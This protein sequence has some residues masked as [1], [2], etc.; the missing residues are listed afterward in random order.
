M[1]HRNLTR[2]RF[3]QGSAA[4]GAALAF[5]LVVPSRVFGANE[6]L[7]IAAIGCGGKGEV[8]TNGVSDQNL[9]A[10]CDVDEKVAANTFAKFPSARRYKDYRVMLEKEAKNI[11]AVTVSTPDHHHAPAAL[12]AM[13]MGKHVYCQKPLTHTVHEARLMRETAA[14]MKVATQMGNQGHSHPETRR[15]VEL[16]RHGVLGKVT[17]VHVWT[18]RPIWP[19]GVRRPADTPPVPPTLDWNLFLGPAPERPYSP[20]YHPF[21]WRGF[22]DFGTGALGD[23]ACH[24]MDLAFFALDLPAP[25]SV[26]AKSSGGNEESAP[27]WSVIDYHFPASG[28]HPALTMTW[29][30]GGRMPP[31][32]VIKGKE[33]VKN[34]IVL[35]GDKDT[36]YV[37]SYWGDGMF[38]SGAKTADFK[39]V[40]QSIPRA[41]GEFDKGHYNEWINACKGGP[42]ALSNFDYS[43]PMTETVLL[44][45]VALRAGQPIEWD[46][47]QLRVTNVPEANRFVK[48]QY[49]QGWGTDV[50]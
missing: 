42:K 28:K 33:M 8:D 21:V 39:D 32:D 10:L 16:V 1:F 24:C 34:G 12:R 6:R 36:L 35:V 49:R 50:A 17:A 23:M 5:P 29:Y 3:L 43:G 25:T 45:N 18:D 20:K 22:W 41:A 7:N 9:V 15:L 40:P 44:G 47:K 37:P 4:A 14:R 26:A 31:A 19:Q 2:R 13:R 30:D 48:K 38:L 46:A 11:D 27:K